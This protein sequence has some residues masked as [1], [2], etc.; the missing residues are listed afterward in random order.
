V[1][2]QFNIHSCIA[3]KLG[4]RMKLF[5]SWQC[6]K[7]P[8]QCTMPHKLCSSP[9]YRLFQLGNWHWWHF[10]MIFLG[11]TVKTTSHDKL[12]I[13]LKTLVIHHKNVAINVLCFQQWT[14]WRP[15]LSKII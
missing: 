5:P 12:W 2:I 8:L 14:K 15:S 13:A 11:M 1:Y 3:H 4:F 6:S 10:N 7:S 9:W